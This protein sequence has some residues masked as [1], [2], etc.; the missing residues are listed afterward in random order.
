M[1]NDP[2][3]HVSEGGLL[4]FICHRGDPE[5]L[6][7]ASKSRPSS[8][9]LHPAPTTVA[10]SGRQRVPADA[11]LP[12]QSHLRSKP[13]AFSL[14]GRPTRGQMG[15]VLL[16]SSPG[17]TLVMG[18]GSRMSHNCPW[19]SPAEWPGRQCTHR[20]SRA[21][22]GDAAEEGGHLAGPFQGSSPGVPGRRQAP[23]HPQ[24]H[25]RL[26]SQ[27]R[28]LAKHS[29]TG[30]GHPPNTRPL[31]ESRGKSYRY[32]HFPTLWETE[33]K[34]VWV[35]GLL[36]TRVGQRSEQSS[37]RMCPRQVLAPE[38]GALGAQEAGALQVSSCGVGPRPLCGA[39][40]LLMW[41]R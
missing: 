4:P 22:W 40:C 28:L 5:C 10:Q 3:C 34:Q 24:P 1:N 2:S 19:L 41:A 13:P 32:L 11:H 21:G 37:V 27:Q 31:F 17:W 15:A 36:V 38:A 12:T 8:P 16:P 26:R 30:E 14:P 9:G 18:R 7:W 33:A 23:E 35:S 29:Q 6:P 20:G 25:C 39:L